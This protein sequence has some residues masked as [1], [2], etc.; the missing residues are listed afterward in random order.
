MLMQANHTRTL[1]IIVFPMIA[2]LGTFQ[3][4]YLSRSGP[5][6]LLLLRLEHLPPCRTSDLDGHAPPSSPLLP[7]LSPGEPLALWHQ[8]PSLIS[9]HEN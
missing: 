3:L 8:P 6:P 9:K 7:R 2:H 5:V 4:R 1:Y